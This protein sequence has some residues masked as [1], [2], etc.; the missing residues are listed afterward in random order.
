[1]KGFT[2]IELMIAVGIVGILAATAVPMYGDYI[3]R[4]QSVEE[5]MLSRTDKIDCALDPS[6]DKCPP[7]P[8]EIAAAAAEEA[9]DL[10]RWAK[11]REELTECCIQ[12][13]WRLGE[14]VM[15]RY[16]RYKKTGC[17]METD[18]VPG[19]GGGICPSLFK[20]T[21]GRIGVDAFKRKVDMFINRNPDWAEIPYK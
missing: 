2:L 20:E 18:T 11:E 13:H 16:Y 8:E 12:R 19:K 4:A 6:L 1:M 17:Y 10:A 5:H 7:T 3:A 9:A 14:S 15:D 21:E